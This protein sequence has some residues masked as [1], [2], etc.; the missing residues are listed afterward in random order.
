[1]QTWLFVCCLIMFTNLT[2]HAR[3]FRLLIL[4]EACSDDRLYVCVGVNFRGPP[5]CEDQRCVAADAGRFVFPGG[6]NRRVD[7]PGRWN[8]VA[9]AVTLSRT[10][11]DPHCARLTPRGIQKRSSRA[12]AHRRIPLVKKPGSTREGPTPEQ[13]RSASSERRSCNT[14]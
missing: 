14:F 1:M 10:W 3:T 9:K 4:W 11:E 5:F 12:R 6:T 13:W 2:F 8:F 7:L